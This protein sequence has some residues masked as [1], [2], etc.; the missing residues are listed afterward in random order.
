[1]GQ[2]FTFLDYKGRIAGYF[3]WIHKDPLLANSA[4][5]G[6]PIHSYYPLSPSG[7]SQ[8][9]YT[10]GCYGPTP[11]VWQSAQLTC[12]R[13]PMIDGMLEA[14]GPAVGQAVGAFALRHQRMALVAFSC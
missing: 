13:S 8:P 2:P 10:H 7:L 14:G 11:P 12:V 3:V 1:M 9:A 4:R 5:S 6:A